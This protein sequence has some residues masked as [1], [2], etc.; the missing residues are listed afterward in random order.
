MYGSSGSRIPIVGV[1]PPESAYKRPRSKGN[2]PPEASV[3]SRRKGSPT[4]LPDHYSQADSSEG[5]SGR[6]RAPAKSPVVRNR[7]P[8]RSSQRTAAVCEMEDSAP[9]RSPSSKA[10][11]SSRH[12]HPRSSPPRLATGVARETLRT[13]GRRQGESHAEFSLCQ[14][15]G[16]RNLKQ[17]L[18]DGLTQHQQHEAM[19][20]RN[21]G[22][23]PDQGVISARSHGVRR[24]EKYHVS[25]DDLAHASEAD[26]PALIKR[27]DSK[28][29]DKPSL[30]AELLRIVAKKGSKPL[31][32]WIKSHGVDIVEVSASQIQENEASLL[33][34]AAMFDHG[35][36]VFALADAGLRCTLSELAKASPE[37]LGILLQHSADVLTKSQD[38][39]KEVL[40]QLAQR[41]SNI[42]NLALEGGSASV[43]SCKVLEKEAEKNALG[44]VMQLTRAG[45]IVTPEALT[46]ALASQ[47]HSLAW[48]MLN[49]YVDNN[50][51]D[52]LWNDPKAAWTVMCVAISIGDVDVIEKLLYAKNNY[53][54][55]D[56]ESELAMAFAVSAKVSEEQGS[57]IHVIP[58]QLRTHLRDQPSRMARRMEII[59]MLKEDRRMAR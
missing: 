33:L 34:T 37:L 5:E 10:D 15:S 39:R 46:I 27:A 1:K 9:S 22:S 40:I 12:D 44:S 13:L 19:H 18:I 42:R 50:P 30:A 8:Q 55:Q 45:A 36:T 58:R 16:I 7:S 31:L 54:W 21:A 26:M 32:D 49:T 28:W 2:S 48:A 23:W 52:E 3:K 41:K 14:D 24:R 59:K 20:S 38:S 43:D 56:G 29:L 57:R 35:N 51:L 25:I 53:S 11:E 4:L 47:Q 6:A 17:L